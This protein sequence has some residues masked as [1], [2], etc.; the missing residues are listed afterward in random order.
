[1]PEFQVT[2]NDVM[3]SREVRFN[4]RQES[5]YPHLMRLCM[6]FK[7]RVLQLL[8]ANNAPDNTK[9]FILVEAN[10]NG[11][12]LTAMTP[13]TRNLQQLETLVRQHQIDI[14][15]SYLFGAESSSG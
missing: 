3:G 12:P 11:D 4:N 5:M 1:M 9:A 2:A 7:F 8:L 10:Y 6:D 13:P 15:H 14:L